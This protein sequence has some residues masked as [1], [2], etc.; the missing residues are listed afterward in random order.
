MKKRIYKGKVMDQ[1]IHIYCSNCVNGKEL[2]D[3]IILNS[4]YIPKD[5]DECHPWNPE[6]SFP[7]EKRSRYK[8]K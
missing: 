1:D 6:D 7:F 5:C 4:R 2:F 3:A 8:E